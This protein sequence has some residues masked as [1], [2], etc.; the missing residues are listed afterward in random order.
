MLEIMT[1]YMR[2][3]PPNIWLGVTVENQQRADGRIPLLLQCPATVRYV[4]IEPMLGPVDLD[5]Y[6]GAPEGLGEPVGLDWI[7]VGG[8]TGPGARPMNPDWA[9]DVRDQCKAA[10]VPF[11]FK[12]MAGKAPIPDDLMIREWPEAR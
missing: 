9:R 11:F 6:W 4:S 7:I 5:A 12:Q 8:E 1:L 2:T 10:G 3:P